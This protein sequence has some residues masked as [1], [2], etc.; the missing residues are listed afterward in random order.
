MSSPADR[1][2]DPHA[3]PRQVDAD[4]LAHEVSRDPDPDQAQPAVCEGPFVVVER[5][6][7]RTCGLSGWR[8]RPECRSIGLLR[9]AIGGVGRPAL[10]GSGAGH[11]A[12]PSRSHLGGGAAFGRRRG[13]FRLDARPLW[14]G[15]PRRRFRGRSADLD[16]RASPLGAGQLRAS[17]RAPCLPR[18]SGRSAVCPSVFR[19]L[20]AGLRQLGKSRIY[21]AGWT[22]AGV[23]RVRLA[24]PADLALRAARRR[25][26][27]RG[28]LPCRQDLYP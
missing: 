13:R 5:A 15:D 7:G 12:E 25:A 6:P 1:L 16:L 11:V 20:L 4:C 18:P 9:K 3:R 23:R 14:A 8:E 28:S 26:A 17:H 10:T 24:D 22:W 2:A 27:L 19:P 21:F